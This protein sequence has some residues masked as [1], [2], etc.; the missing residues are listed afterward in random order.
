MNRIYLFLALLVAVLISFYVSFSLGKTEERKEWE[1]KYALAEIEIKTL[2]AKAPVINEVI[3]T[4]F[5][6]KIS[7]IDRVKVQT[8]K[9][10]ITVEN[11]KA[12]VINQG[13][14]KIH[15][16]A[17]AAIPVV[18][19]ASDADPSAVQLSNVAEVVKDN[20]AVHQ[21]TK[22]QLESLQQWIKDQQALWNEIK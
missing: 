9:E 7:Y 8:V 10:F 6:D 19:A 15:D 3:V 21:K 11:D 1:H 12:C 18:P 2:E 22:I 20:Y 14:V 5:V 17:A 4:K 13:F 16:G